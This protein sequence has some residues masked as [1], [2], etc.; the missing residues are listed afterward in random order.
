MIIYIPTPLRRYTRRQAL[1]ESDARTLLE[2][3]TNMEAVFPALA[4]H[5]LDEGT[6]L[7]A[8]IRLLVNQEQVRSLEVS[9]RP[10]DEVHILCAPQVPA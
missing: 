4:A 9:L 6:R 5:L 1:F 3:L 10:E 7:R 2:L 8:H